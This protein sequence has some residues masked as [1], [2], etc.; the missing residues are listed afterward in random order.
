[1]ARSPWLSRCFARGHGSKRLLTRSL[2][3]CA[4]SAIWWLQDKIETGDDVPAEDLRELLDLMREIE[5]KAQQHAVSALNP[6]RSKAM[7]ANDREGVY[8]PKTNPYIW[9]GI[10]VLIACPALVLLLTE[11]LR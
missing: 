10:A 2:E 6:R 9:A 11:I 8:I 1:M 5:A 7:S 4:T 3:W